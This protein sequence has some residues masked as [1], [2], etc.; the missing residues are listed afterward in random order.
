MS[1]PTQ[2]DTAENRPLRV[3]VVPHAPYALTFGG[4]EVQQL[5]TIKALQEIGIDVV[6]YD[7]W[8]RAFDVDVIH[9]FGTEYPH[10]EIIERARQQRIPVVA[11]AMFMPERPLWQ[12]SL[13]RRLQHVMPE[14]TYSLRQRSLAGADRIIAISDVERSQLVRAYGVDVGKISVIPNG[15]DE[16]F[17]HADGAAFQ[18]RYGVR[19]CVLCVASIEPRKNQVAV[20][21][22]LK[23]L[24]KPVVFVGG[25]SS[26]GGAE[27]EMYASRFRQIV[28]SSSNLHWI[29]GLAHDD[30]LLE[31]AYATAH[32]HILASIA[33]AQGLSTM[34]AAAA[35]AHVIVSD[36]PNLRTIFGAD[37]RYV[38]PHSATSIRS[39]VAQ[40]FE[41]P[42]E[43]MSAARPP[44]LITWRNVANALRELY[45][46]TISPR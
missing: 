14:T 11:V 5:Q 10:T 33:E 45:D 16:R 28:A 1:R 6:R 8:M 30:P 3:L 15:I 4:M 24:G 43:G 31:G 13:M 36:L 26:H 9:V 38:D 22:A 25:V 34:E 35:G 41:R 2:N 18:A 19:D 42:R 27:T 12:F 37:V 44:W 40:A 39:A 21:E 17:F 46:V 32:V 7:P 20:A 29:E 23:D